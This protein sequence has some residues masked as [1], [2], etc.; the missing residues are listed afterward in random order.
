VVRVWT[1]GSPLFGSHDRVTVE[2]FAGL[3]AGYTIDL[4]ARFFVGVRIEERWS[5]AQAHSS[6]DASTDAVVTRAWTFT[7]ALLAG[8]QI[9]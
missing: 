3:A 2:A 5:P 9:F 8:W 6:V 1:K 4:P 7:A